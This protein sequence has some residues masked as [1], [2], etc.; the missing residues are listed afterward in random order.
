MEIYQILKLVE[1]D[2]NAQ[3]ARLMILIYHLCGENNNKKIDGINKLAKL[4]FLLK[5]PKFLQ[6]GLLKQNSKSTISITNAESKSIEIKMNAFRYLPWDENYRKLL[7]IIIAKGLAKISFEKD[8]YFIHIT[9]KGIELVERLKNDKYFKEFFNRSRV[10][11]TNFGSYSERYLDN[12]F[13]K[14]FPEIGSFKTLD[15]ENIL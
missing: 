2:L 10:I 13:E 14:H 11:N 4:D 8:D 7:N 1:N 15:N 12:F 5:S 9:T 3:L 6:R